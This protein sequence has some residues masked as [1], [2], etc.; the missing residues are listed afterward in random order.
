MKKNRD[1]YSKQLVRFILFFGRPVPDLINRSDLTILF[2]IRD[3]RDICVSHLR[4]LRKTHSEP[5]NAGSKQNRFINKRRVL[6]DLSDEA[7]Y[8]EIFEEIKTNPNE[9][10]HFL[11]NFRGNKIVIRYEDLLVNPSQLYQILDDHFD[12]KMSP[13]EIEKIGYVKVQKI[14]SNNSHHRSGDCG[15]Y[16]RS[17]P[18]ALVEEMNHHWEDFLTEFCY[19]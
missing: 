4:S 9:M 1:N 3:P 16:A 13:S 5:L 10:L 8:R 14:V 6:N 18:V 19:S 11:R 15:Q 2:L 12:K 17:L 7:A